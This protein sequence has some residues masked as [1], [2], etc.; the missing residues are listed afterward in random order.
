MKTNKLFLGAFALLLA[1]LT[2]CSDEEPVG[3]ASTPTAVTDGT[4]KYMSVIISTAGDNGDSGRANDSDFVAGEGS[5]CTFGAND[6]I[7]LFYD[8][9]GNPFPL[10]AAN[11]AG[12]TTSNAVTPTTIEVEHG[13]GGSPV[14]TASLVLG[15]A[16]GEG[17]VGKTPTQ[18]LCLINIEGRFELSNVAN[19]RMSTVINMTASLPEAGL[20]GN[21]SKFL[22]SNSTYLDADGALVQSV[23][24][25]GCFFDTPEAA[26]SSPVTF[27]VERVVAKVRVAG[28]G[29]DL[30]VQ[31]RNAET[32]IATVADY[33]VDNN[34]IPLQVQLTAWRLRNLSPSNYVIKHIAANKDYFT[35]WNDPVRHRCYWTEPQ[36]PTGLQNVKYELYDETSDFAVKNQNWSGDGDV[37]NVVYCLENTRQPESA[38]D[39]NSQATGIVVKAVVKADFDKD[40]TYEPVDLIRWAGAY[41]TLANFKDIVAQNYNGVNGT[42]LTADNVTI[43]AIEGENN[44]YQAYIK[45][46]TNTQP[47]ANFSNLLW[48]KNGVTSYYINVEHSIGSTKDKKLY[49]VVRNHI[50]HYEIDGVIGLGVPGNNT[51]V[52]DEEESFLS[53]KLYCLNWRVINNKVTLE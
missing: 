24:L 4:E 49:G 52:T 12:T 50:Y 44:Y 17:Y 22:M 6:V 34:D 15:K 7:F 19:K 43:E 35:D 41:Y 53:A 26:Q 36:N 3:P 40:G 1:G 30:P 11:I 48:W 42:S 29:V 2:S 31:K 9:N 27:Y 51:T 25:A 14:Q 45:V 13:P 37:T 16:V 10:A 5:E 38:T 28:L 8:E 47:V 23:P 18:A 20:D 46:G 32:G 39:R 33:N 21:T